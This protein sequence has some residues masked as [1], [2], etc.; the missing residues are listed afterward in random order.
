MN[1]QRVLLNLK[2]KYPLIYFLLLLIHLLASYFHFFEVD[3]VP[4]H[5]K[6]LTL[7]IKLHKYLRDLYLILSL[8]IFHHTPLELFL[9]FCRNPP[10]NNFYHSQFIH[11]QINNNDSPAMHCQVLLFPANHI[12]MF[13]HNSE[14][15]D[16]LSQILLHYLLQ[17][18]QNSKNYSQM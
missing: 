3:L 15:Q 5:Y 1:Q 16:C 4:F 18:H 11:K 10:L 9:D 14:N 12:H 6:F 17:N 7:K 13:N 8:K 2:H